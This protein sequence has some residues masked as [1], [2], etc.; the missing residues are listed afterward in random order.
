LESY[1]A[2]SLG[3]GGVELPSGERTARRLVEREPFRES[4][5]RLLMR[6]LAEGGNV[7]DALR[8][9]ECLATLLR[10]ELGVDPGPA[11]QDL[12]RSLL[13]TT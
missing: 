7:A 13:E 10:D 6:A 9:Y 5:H 3:I 8:V 2:P 12:H 4:G 1:A 11:T